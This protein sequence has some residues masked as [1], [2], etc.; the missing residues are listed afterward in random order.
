MADLLNGT[1]PLHPQ[2]LG[3]EHCGGVVGVRVI[4]AHV[5]TTIGEQHKVWV[6]W[7]VTPHWWCHIRRYLLPKQHDLLAQYLKTRQR[8]PLRLVEASL[9]QAPE[10]VPVGQVGLLKRA[11]DLVYSLEPAILLTIIIIGLKIFL[12]GTGHWWVLYIAGYW[13]LL[14]TGHCWIL[15]IAGYWT[16]L[17]TGH[18][19]I[20][21]SYCW[22]LLIVNFYI[23]P[24]MYFTLKFINFQ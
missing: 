16:L 2:L 6:T 13:T 12:L 21:T 5:Q 4:G 18:C 20:L 15:D 17:G 1:P 23:L 14:G 3:P 10:L 11:A 8:G 22:L 9:Y 24:K 7:R 19:W